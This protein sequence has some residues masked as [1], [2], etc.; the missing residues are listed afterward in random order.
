ME[1]SAGVG[2]SDG[3]SETSVASLT[4]ETISAG[5]LPVGLVGD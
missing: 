4:G 5:D 2:V 3:G 1:L